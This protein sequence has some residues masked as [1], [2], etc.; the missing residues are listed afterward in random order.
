M[1]PNWGEC[2][3]P[4]W[5]DLIF[6][7]AFQKK[8]LPNAVS[9][10]ENSNEQARRDPSSLHWQIPRSP[11]GTGA[12]R[13]GVGLRVVAVTPSLSWADSRSGSYSEPNLRSLRIL[14]A[15]DSEGKPKL[16]AAPEVPE[17]REHHPTTSRTV[18]RIAQPECPPSRFGPCRLSQAA[19]LALGSEAP[20]PR[21]SALASKDAGAL[22]RSSLSGRRPSAIWLSD[23]GPSCLARMVPG[24]GLV[25][26][27]APA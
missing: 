10:K 24:F 27:P 9:M 23:S 18:L 26:E 2:R 5:V 17:G 21:R 25:G 13:P 11:P 15:P 12:G 14:A 22:S 16:K 7:S 3:L 1:V 6:K 4:F 19:A 20:Y 8:D